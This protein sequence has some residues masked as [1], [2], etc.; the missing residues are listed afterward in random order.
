MLKVQ[1]KDGSAFCRVGVFS[2]LI[3]CLIGIVFEK[4]LK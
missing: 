4:G 1:H 2:T 3:S